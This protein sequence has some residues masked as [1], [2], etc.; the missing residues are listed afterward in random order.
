MMKCL[1]KLY[2]KL[3]VLG[4]L[5]GLQGIFFILILSSLSGAILGSIMLWRNKKN[6]K[7][8]LPFG[9]YIIAATFIYIF[10]GPQ[11]IEQVE[12]MA[13]HYLMNY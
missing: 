2:L 4:F 7:T 5:F 9:P 8:Q 13:M 12:A 6:F 10:I 11:M 1:K 3:V